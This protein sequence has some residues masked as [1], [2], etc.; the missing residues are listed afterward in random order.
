MIDGKT[1]R[2][3]AL[4]EADLPHLVRFANSRAV[5]RYLVNFRLPVSVADE[6]AFLRRMRRSATDRVYS[7]ETRRGRYVGTVGFHD[8]DPVDRACE[9]GLLIATPRD[10]GRGFA[11]EA[12]RL[13]LVVGFERQ[14]LNRL[15]VPVLATNQVACAM[16]AQLG[17]TSEGRLRERRFM[18]GRYV[19]VISFSILAREYRPKE[20]WR[21]L[22]ASD[23]KLRR[24][25]RTIGQPS[26][27]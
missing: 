21:H 12:I 24:K 5:T 19:D 13:G 14:N 2:L 3:R 8:I 20:N 16:Y 10:W 15:A 11:A 23:D 7:V 17:F 9:F 4:A 27:R 18:D 1:L 6:R 26:G 25:P 22:G